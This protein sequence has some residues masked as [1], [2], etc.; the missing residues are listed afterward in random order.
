M[1]PTSITISLQTRNSTE[2]AIPHVITRIQKAVENHTLH[3]TFPRYW[4]SFWQHFTW[5]KKTSKWHGLKDTVVMDH[6]HAGWQKNYSHMPRRYSVGVSRQLLS[7]EGHF[8]TPALLPGCR[9][10]R[11]PRWEWLLWTGVCA[12]ISGKFVVSDSSC[13]RL[14]VWNNGVVNSS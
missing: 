11:G 2:T 7:T 9:W 12:I 3:F 8:I 4:G 10:N 14:W 6:L 5:H 13:R 1:L